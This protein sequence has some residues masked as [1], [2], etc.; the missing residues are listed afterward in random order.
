LLYGTNIAT[1]AGG[2]WIAEHITTDDAAI[3][4]I[5][6]L[7]EGICKG[8]HTYQW[9]RRIGVGAIRI[10][11]LDGK[12]RSIGI[13]HIGVCR[14]DQTGLAEEKSERIGILIGD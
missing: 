3:N 5:D 9:P 7:V 14:G 13:H 2:A 12:W 6:G 11:V 10:D 1:P 4:W 8:D